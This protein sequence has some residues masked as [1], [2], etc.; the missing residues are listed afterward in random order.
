MIEDREVREGADDRLQH[1]QIGQQLADLAMSVPT[2]SN[3]ALYGA[4]G[5]GKS[6]VGNLVRCHLESKGH[7]DKRGEVAFARFDA[8]KYAENPLRRNFVTAMATELGIDD[9]AFHEDLYAGT[10]NT[11]LK[12]PLGQTARLVAIFVA[13]LG[14]VVALLTGGCLLVAWLQQGDTSDN[15]GKIAKVL[16][17]A[18]LAPAALL[19]AF[20][21]LGG[22]TLNVDRRIDKADSHE[23][24]EKLFRS[25]VKKTGK[26]VV[27]FVDELDR[28]SASNVVATLDAMRCAH[29]SVS[30][31]ACSSS[32]PTAR[33]SNKR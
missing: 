8:F 20:V 6:G 17:A 18:A 33:C 14:L 16:F 30:P 28:C 25:L 7:L 23:Q 27:V 21:A 10:T 1:G 11:K 5:S 29:S 24:F 2:P 4:W 22:K 32:L 9:D 19:A 31:D 12:F 3:I 26:K 13:F 15:F